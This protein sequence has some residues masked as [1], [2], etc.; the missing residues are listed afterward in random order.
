MKLFIKKNYIIIISIFIVFSFFGYT[1]HKYLKNY[2]LYKEYY[3]ENHSES[4]LSCKNDIQYYNEN[5]ETCDSLILYKENKTNI[6]NYFYSIV[7]SADWHFPFF[8]ILVISIPALYNFHYKVK[9]G[10]IKNIFVRQKYNTFLLK[11][12]C[13][14]L[15]AS[16]I[17]PITFVILFIY[18]GIISNW[19]FDVKSTSDL[20]SEAHLYGGHLDKINLFTFVFF[21][22]IWLHSVFYI[23]IGYIVDKKSNNFLVT[24]IGILLVFFMCEIFSEVFGGLVINN[25][26]GLTQLYEAMLLTNIWAYDGINNLWIITLFSLFLAGITT[27]IVYIMYNKKENLI[28]GNG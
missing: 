24:C 9:S 5:H 23:N 27:F 13:S 22:N 17:I 20:F 19:N 12:Y 7:G 11:E 2:N 14:S 26:F 8:V 15:K 1:A 21:I 10:F 18:C 28:I 3:I 16:L 4:Y 6:Y 25:I